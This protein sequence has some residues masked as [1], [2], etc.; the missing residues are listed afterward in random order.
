MLEDPYWK[1]HQDALMIYKSIA[2]VLSR[3]PTAA[4]MNEKSNFYN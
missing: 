1:I 4:I 2:T 3:W